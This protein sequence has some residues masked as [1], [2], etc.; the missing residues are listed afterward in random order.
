MP[1]KKKPR[2]KKYNPK[3]HQSIVNRNFKH[4]LEEGTVTSI[5]SYQRNWED[6]RNYQWDLY[7]ELAYQR[8]QVIEEIKKSLIIPSSHNFEF[9]KWQQLVKYRYCLY[10]YSTKG[11]VHSIGG[12]FNIETIR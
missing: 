8:E 12:R 10:P 5:K 4:F 9:N 1:K 2:K 11:S 3:K 6:Y 7:N